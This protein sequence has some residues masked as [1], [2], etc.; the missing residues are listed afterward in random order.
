MNSY[1]ISF[2]IVILILIAGCSTIAKPDYSVK[3][4]L[5]IEHLQSWNEFQADG[6]IIAN[7]NNFAFRKNIHIKKK[8]EYMKITVFDSG[9][10]GMK[11]E[12][13]TTI[14]I[15]SLITIKTQADVNPA[16]YKINEFPGIEYLLNPAKL[17]QYSNKIV[18][19]NQLLLTDT[20]QIT[21]SE[22]MQ[23]IQIDDLISLKRIKLEYQNELRSIQILQNNEQLAKIEIDKITNLRN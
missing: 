9:I 11:P 16:I 10:F 2:S 15:D 5:L 19:N 7:Y 4:K 22:K 1:R 21:F 20:V 8:N 6:I 23:I 17:I 14:T 18:L 3:E 12:P 13:F